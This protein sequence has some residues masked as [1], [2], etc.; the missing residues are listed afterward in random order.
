MLIENAAF[1][2]L[3]LGT[4]G[5]KAAG[6]FDGRVFASVSDKMEYIKDGGFIEYDATVFYGKIARLIQSIAAKLPKGIACKGICVS[7]ASGNTLLCDKNGRPLTRAI[8][9]MDSRYADEAEEITG[10]L[11]RQEMYHLTGWPFFGAMTLAHLAWLRTH[12]KGL[13]QNADMACMSADYVNYRLTGTRQTDTS[14]ATTSYLQD[15]LGRRWHKP[16]VSALELDGKL[17]RLC[18]TGN[19]AGALTSVAADETGLKPGT[20]VFLGS[21]DHPSAARGAGTLRPGDLL[22][23]CG[24]SWVSFLPCGDRSKLLELELLCDPFLAEKGIW[25]GM[26]SIPGVS[27][28]INDALKYA[29]P[30]N[31]RSNARFNALAELCP[32]GAGGLLINPMKAPDAA[33]LESFGPER[34]ARSLMEGTAY[35]LRKNIND[36]SNAGMRIDS[37]T[38]VG[39]PSLSSTW[40]QIVCDVL[41]MPVKTVNGAYAGAVGAALIAAVSVGAY[42]N[43]EIA[44][45]HSA[46]IP[47]YKEPNPRHSA[48]YAQ[49]YSRFIAECL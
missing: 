20:P 21:F 29:L 33:F 7:S 31:E 37:V 47:V 11:S 44:A 18:D 13:Y 28:K 10:S 30:P 3:D 26:K 34:A 23:S 6:L 22:L 42:A 5:L 19:L 8:S 39:G 41:S 17:P 38:M 15:Q 43:I 25:A 9:W 14:T 12:K 48:V 46:G 45:K 24:T 40:M 49:G 32:A 2:G 1:I 16:F 4:T 35:L 27:V 36:L